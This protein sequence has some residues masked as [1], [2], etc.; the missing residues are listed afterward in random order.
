M[1]SR[2]HFAS[3]LDKYELFDLADVLKFGILE[4]I[5]INPPLLEYILIYIYIYVYFQFT[6][7]IYDSFCI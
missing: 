1:S 7:S 5:W 6:L 3:G 4:C 2:F